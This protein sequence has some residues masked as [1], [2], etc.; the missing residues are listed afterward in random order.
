MKLQGKDKIV[1]GGGYKLNNT[2]DANFTME[3]VVVDLKTPI[4][5]PDSSSNDPLIFPNPVKEMLYFGH[6]AAFEIRDIQGKVLLKSVTPI[7]SVYTGSLEAGV[8]LVR[9]D[10][11]GV[12]KFVKE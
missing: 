3:R 5:L 12:R 9:L 4:P 1:L 2:Y 8:Y 6:E 11:K 10:G 7:G